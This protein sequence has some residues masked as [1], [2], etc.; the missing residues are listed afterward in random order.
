V[1]NT[2]LGQNDKVS[3]LA[4]LL[5]VLA[6]LAVGSPAAAALKTHRCPDDPSAHCGTLVVPLDRAGV[7]KGTIPIRFAYK[8][9]LRRATPIV[10]LSGGPGQ[11]G[12]ILLQDFAD[13]LRP[14]TRGRRAVIV[15]DQ[16]GTGNSG[17]LRCRALEKADLLKAGK[18]AASCASKLGPRRDYYTTDDTV[19]DMD[20]LRAALGVQKWSVY[21]VSYGTKV[22]VQY[23]QRHPDRVERLVLDSIVEPGGPDPLYG[24]TLPGNP[25]R[26]GRH[27]RA[28]ALQLGVEER[29]CRHLQ[30]D[31]QARRRSAQ[32]LRRGS[33]RPPP[34]AHF[35]PQPPFRHAADGRLRRIAA[36]RVAD[37]RSAPRW[38]ATRRRSSAWP[39]APLRS[40][41]AETTR[42]S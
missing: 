35:R 8:G 23:A 26:P 41:A 5:P 38:A 27:L 36:G 2:V 14:A 24:T 39:T 21:G 42:T 3:R 15:L 30:A 16:R 1:G 40:R 4:A 11:A 6:L 13:S 7:V 32:G 10:A 18:E 29:R 22:A 25:T 9:N 17:L 19:A 34:E 37:R 28:R 31:R 12:V 33:R 20:A